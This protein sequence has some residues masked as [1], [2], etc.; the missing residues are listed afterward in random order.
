MRFPENARNA[1]I[2][3][4][5]TWLLVGIGVPSFVM[6]F[7][8]LLPGGVVAFA[9]WQASSILLGVLIALQK[10]KAEY[11]AALGMFLFAVA[12]GWAGVLWYI[13]TMVFDF[14]A[15]GLGL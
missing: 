6:L 1:A 11:I 14:F 3:I 4:L 9:V 2:D 10:R 5:I 13:I 15:G 8:A 12:V 7:S